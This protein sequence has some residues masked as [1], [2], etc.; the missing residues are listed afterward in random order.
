MLMLEPVIEA[1]NLRELQTNL[2]TVAGHCWNATNCYYL[3]YDDRRQVL[4]FGNEVIIPEPTDQVGLAALNLAVCDDQ[5]LSWPACLPHQQ[6]YRRSVPIF[7]WGGLVGILCLEFSQDPGELADFE[8]LERTLGHLTAR[9]LDKEMSA[10]FMTRCKE[11][12]VRGVEAQGK[13]GH[14]QRLSRLV[15]SLA[16][17]L[18]FSPQVKSDLLEAAQYHDIGLLTFEKPNSTEAQ[19]GHPQVGASLLNSHTEFFEVAPSR[20]SGD[21]LPLECWVLSLA[22][23]FV[24]FWETSVSSYQGK[25]K[26][27]FAGN[28]KHHHPDVVDAL[29]GLVDSGELESLLS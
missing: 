20:K 18:D 1:T 9:V 17:L 15:G 19:Q 8:E 22:E 14:I 21:E 5:S 12:L 10:Q 26:E 24:E 16:R 29:C 3:T 25:I 27:F 11:L 23:D 7:V 28:A 4:S 2:A 6:R 13:A